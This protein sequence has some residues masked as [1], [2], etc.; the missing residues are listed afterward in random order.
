[1]AGTMYPKL[2]GRIVEKYG[3]NEKFAEKLG[4]SIITVS[5]KLNGRT[6]FSQADVVEWSGL[7]D[8]NIADVG[9]FFYDVKV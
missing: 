7:L 5:G 3:T 1:M 2:R 8:I 6:S 4:K 9:S